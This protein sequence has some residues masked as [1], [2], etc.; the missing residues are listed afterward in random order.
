MKGVSFSCNDSLRLPVFGCLFSLSLKCCLTV[1]IY[2][3]RLCTETIVTRRAE[4]WSLLRSAAFSLVFFSFFLTLYKKKKS[5]GHLLFGL[6]LGGVGCAAGG[7]ERG[8]TVKCYRNSW[9]KRGNGR[10]RTSSIDTDW[11]GARLNGSSSRLDYGHRVVTPLKLL[12][13]CGEATAIYGE[14]I[15]LVQRSKGCGQGFRMFLHEGEFQ[16]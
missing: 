10:Y 2:D 5:H 9:L 15:A 13:Q 8:R 6:A 3:N 12:P 4:S 14:N 11:V 7:R 16:L 1:P